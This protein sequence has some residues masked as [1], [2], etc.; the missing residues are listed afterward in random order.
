MST[1]YGFFHSRTRNVCVCVHIIKWANKI[2]IKICYRRRSEKKLLRINFNQT[3][4]D[5]VHVA[6]DGK[7]LNLWHLLVWKSTLLTTRNWRKKKQKVL[8]WC[9]Q[10]LRADGRSQKAEQSRA[11]HEV[12]I[13]HEDYAQPKLKQLNLNDVSQ[14]EARK[15]SFKPMSVRLWY[16]R[17]VLL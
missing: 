2:A 7:Y 1:F 8:T 17:F 13:A 6:E 4:S 3:Q 10:I 5:F 16:V 9:C 12:E 14:L 11:E 15:F